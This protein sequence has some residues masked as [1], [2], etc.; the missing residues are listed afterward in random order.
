MLKQIF[1]DSIATLIRPQEYFSTMPKEGGYKLPIMK[2]IIYT[3][4]SSI[5]GIIPLLMLPLAGR[6]KIAA[7]SIFVIAPISGI[8][9]LF[10]GALGY[11]LSSLICG[12]T[13]KYEAATRV[14]ASIMVISPINVALQLF[15]RIHFI[16]GN[17]IIF[18]LIA[19]TIYLFYKGMV[20][21]LSCKPLRT[22]IFCIVI[23]L[24][25]IGLIIFYGAPQKWS[26]RNRANRT[27]GQI[28]K[29]KLSEYAKE[30]QKLNKEYTEALKSGDKKK[31]EEIKTKIK[32]MEEEV[33]EFI[34]K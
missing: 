31:Q 16:V 32:K 34:K 33:S 25:I 4:L 14:C 15:G 24:V 9:G 18:L 28:H 5:V 17:A 21:G 26:V 12:G 8:L 6:I 30:A 3:V 7:L 1:Q 2:G 10:I 29:N 19:Y 13:K 23:P 22:K 11:L 27:I 20:Y